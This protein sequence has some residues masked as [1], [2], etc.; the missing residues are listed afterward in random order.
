MPKGMGYSEG[1]QNTPVKMG[2]KRQNNK[3][4]GG[5]LG[6]SMGAFGKGKGG[7]DAG[8]VMYEGPAGATCSNGGN[9][10]VTEGSAR[11]FGSGGK[12]KY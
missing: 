3:Q 11:M 5:N 7:K 10:N 1:M 2:N 6:Y 8:G 9:Y 12:M 4:P